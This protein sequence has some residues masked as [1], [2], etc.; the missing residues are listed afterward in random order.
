VLYPPRATSVATS[1]LTLSTSW[2]QSR[3]NLP[4]IIAIAVDAPILQASQR[5]A[6]LTLECPYEQYLGSPQHAGSAYR[7]IGGAV[8]RTVTLRLEH[9]RS[10]NT[11]IRLS[12]FLFPSRALAPTLVQIL[13]GSCA[14]TLLR[15]PAFCATRLVSLL[16]KL[17]GSVFLKPPQS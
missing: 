9:A 14:S 15:A 10:R 16:P 8:P 13:I 11:N 4:G 6:Y 7:R 1:S 2:E 17:N 12:G 5:S 3:K